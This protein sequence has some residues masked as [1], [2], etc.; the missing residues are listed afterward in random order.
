MVRNFSKDN[1]VARGLTHPICICELGRVREWGDRGI[2]PNTSII[3]TDA[4]EYET[5][6]PFHS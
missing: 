2:Q 4:A 5:R 3:V 6:K 1:F